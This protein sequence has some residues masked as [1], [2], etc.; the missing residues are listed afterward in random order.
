MTHLH[1]FNEKD[2]FAVWGDLQCLAS[3]QQRA[4]QNTTLQ[5]LP[6]QV[7]GN[8][9]AGWKDFTLDLS[10]HTLK[11]MQTAKYTSGLVLLSDSP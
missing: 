4:H 11:H 1:E 5:Q 3:S 8:Q 7:L 10:T 9:S 2:P 6:C